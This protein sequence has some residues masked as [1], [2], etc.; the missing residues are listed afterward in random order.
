MGG[1]FYL[2]V[3]FGPG[4]EGAEVAVVD[5]DVGGDFA[6]ALVDGGGRR[7]F[8]GVVGVDGVEV[9]TALGAPVDGLLKQLSLA[10]SPQYELQVGIILL[11]LAQCSHGKGALLA[12]GGI[13][14]VDNRTVEVYS[15]CHLV[16]D[17]FA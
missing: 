12:D 13:T 8:V 9:E 14:M 10:D 7:Q 6:A 16:M 3:D 4:G 11:H 15:N 5:V 17:Q 2:A 1:A